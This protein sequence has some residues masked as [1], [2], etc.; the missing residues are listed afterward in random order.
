MQSKFQNKALYPKN[1]LEVHFITS[2]N[3]DFQYY[4]N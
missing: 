3:S 2:Y 1:T 4:G